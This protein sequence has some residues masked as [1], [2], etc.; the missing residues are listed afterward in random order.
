MSLALVEYCLEDVIKQIEFE[1]Y[2][3]MS[4][5][6]QR[7]EINYDPECTIKCDTMRLNQVLVNLIG[8]ANKYSP[9][10]SL[11]QLDITEE[12]GHLL[13]SVSDEGVGLSAEEISKLFKPF[14][15]IHIEGISHGSGLGLSVCKGI[16]ELH[17]GEIWAES[18][19]R[20]KGSMFKFKIPCTK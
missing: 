6:N 13:F 17:G 7:L 16:I 15:N 3:I 1:F 14:P 2:P 4:E 11:I 18:E 12:D 8:N 9:E 10:G 20:G 19:G 5:K